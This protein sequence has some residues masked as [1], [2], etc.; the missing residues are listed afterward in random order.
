M[1]KRIVL[2]AI[3]L[4]SLALLSPPLY[5]YPEGADVPE[6]VRDTWIDITQPPYNATPDD[7]SDDTEAFRRAF[8]EAYD[9]ASREDV[10]DAT[11]RTIYV[12]D[13]V[14]H[15]S[16]TLVY[17]R[18]PNVGGLNIVGQSR[19]GTI[20]RLPDN[21]EGFD[22]PQAPRPVI[23]YWNDEQDPSVSTGGMA[24]H[25]YLWNIT[26][27]TGSGNPGAI[28]VDFYNNNVGGLRNVRI[29]SRDGQGHSGLA[30]PRTKAGV[31]Y[32]ENLVI[33]GFD[34]GI[35][36]DGNDGNGFTFEGVTLRGQNRF[37]IVSGRKRFHMRNVVSENEVP[38][39]H[40]STRFGNVVM[41]DSEL[42]GG[43]A[44]QP[45]IQYRE[46]PLMLRNVAI[47][48]YGELA[49]VRNGDP[50]PLPG[51]GRV[52]QFL[53]NAAGRFTDARDDLVFTLFD[54]APGES[55]GLPIQDPPHVA[56]ETDHASWRIVEDAGDPGANR[57]NLQDA[58]DS[59]ATTIYIKPGFVEID[60]PLYIRGHVQRI[61]GGFGHLR[62]R[63]PLATDTDE[64]ALVI[65][66]GN[67]PLIIEGFAKFGGGVTKNILHRGDRPL[68]IRD[69]FM[70]NA[71]GTFY[72]NT[73]DAELFIQNVKTRQSDRRYRSYE[74][75][76][77]WVF[78]GGQRVWAWNLN[79]EQ[80]A[81]GQILAQGAT[82]WSLGGKFGERQGPFVMVRDGGRV[83]V[84][85][86]WFNSN[87]GTPGP[88]AVVDGGELAL[89][90]VRNVE[91]HEQNPIWVRE[92]R[93]DEQRE[94]RT[95]DVLVG[96]PRGYL[97]LYRSGAAT[98]VP[99]D[100]SDARHDFDPQ[101]FLAW[102]EKHLN[103]YDQ[104]QADDDAAHALGG[105]VTRLAWSFDPDASGRSGW[106]VLSR[107]F[108]LEEEDGSHFARI[109][110][111]MFATD[112]A[113]E[114]GVEAVRFG[115]RMRAANVPP[116]DERWRMPI[117]MLDIKDA[118]GSNVGPSFQWLTLDGDSDWKELTSDVIA[119]PDEARSITITAGKRAEP[120]L[121]DYDVIWVEVADAP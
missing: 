1:L 93:G 97:P 58:L 83:E 77:T 87:R 24:F 92:V 8:D 45:A 80:Q 111:G 17:S 81:P 59:G 84:L 25:N 13:G 88:M 113:I 112:I 86:C 43:D 100:T 118:E 108:S 23:Q 30:L 22:N 61:H 19:D 21:A 15:I 14:Y 28:G 54:D 26:I 115:T 31:G 79:P 50:A 94:V 29:V 121:V 16:D 5:A 107:T 34:V 49:T 98:V 60:A 114:P 46:G 11:I 2:A 76:P 102:Q 9:Q 110:Q 73:V 51:D 82:L 27:D 56:W 35:N 109:E 42:R 7:G 95:E 91:G 106:R 62:K 33:E 85:G 55:L 105:D 96:R 69:V 99:A 4:V 89:V 6:A 40:M 48:G 3:G 66:D 64:A 47:E 44:S 72:R 20:L 116:T 37:A 38:A 117:V 75:T 57:R 65:E 70:N 32:H 71:Y 18:S 41:I 90:N 68:I 53:L 78:T 103:G 52:D 36:G 101:E 119:V 10:N 39:I 104:D 12:P 74:T 63:P 120:A 67:T